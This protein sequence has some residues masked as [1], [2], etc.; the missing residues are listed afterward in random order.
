MQ[1]SIFNMTLQIQYNYNIVF[2][3]DNDINW[4]NISIQNIA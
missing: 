4:Y 2:E 1:T 3:G